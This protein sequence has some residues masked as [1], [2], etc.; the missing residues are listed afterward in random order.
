MNADGFDKLGDLQKA[1]DKFTSIKDYKDSEDKIDECERKVVA[2]KEAIAKK[3]KRNKTI[4]LIVTPI[5]LF[6]IVVAIIYATVILPKQNYEKAEELFAAQSYSQAYD[7]YAELGDYEDSA[8]KAKECLYIQAVAYRNDKNW[9]AANPLFE[10]IKGYKDS[11]TLIHYHDYKLVDS[12]DATCDTAGYK[13]YTCD[14]G[15]EKKDTISALGHNYSSATCTA[16]KKCSRCEKTEGSALGHTSGGTKCSRCGANTFE[17]LTYTGTGK[18]YIRGI[19]LPSG[20]FVV[21]C[22][23]SGKYN[24]IVYLYNSD[25]SGSELLANEIHSCNT[26]HQLNLKGTLSNA[27]I[28]VALADGSWTI[29]IEAL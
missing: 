7:M 17:K 18:K 29:T 3:K 10:Q 24:F 19:N 5:I 25:G 23:F 12:K 20:Q 16:A 6:A 28:E 26:E 22:S 13:A 21:K 11:D 2:E 8:E 15:Y 9:D 4:A 1:I 27:Y 14:C